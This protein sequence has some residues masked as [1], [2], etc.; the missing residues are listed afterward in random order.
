MLDRLKNQEQFTEKLIPTWPFGCRRLSPGDGYL[1][2]LQ[3]EN[4]SP[5]FSLVIGV[6]DAEGRSYK[7]D[8]I[9]CATG[10][11]TSWC[12]SWPV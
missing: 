8:A 1:E 10:F 9:L 7:V 4:V 2:A 6:E 5:V 11:D 3:E 12:K